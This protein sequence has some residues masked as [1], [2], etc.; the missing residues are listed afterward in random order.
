M[1]RSIS[2]LAFSGLLLSGMV[3]GQDKEKGKPA[4]DA[5]ELPKCAVMAD[6]TIALNVKTNTPDGP[7]YFC[8]PECVDKYAKEP[9]KFADAVK[10]QRAALAK[11]PHV[12]VADPVDG[13]PV[14]KSVILTS[15]TDKVYF[16][17]ED[18]K[19][20]YEA[21]P[22]KYKGGLLN[23]YTYQTTC[24]LM[25]EAIDPTAFVDLADG[26]RVYL[27]CKKCPSKLTADPAKY[28][29][30]LMAMGIMLDMDKINAEA[31]KAGA[32]EKKDEKKPTK[33]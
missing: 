4:A 5:A 8:C 9:A 7:V 31:T 18:N 19:K 20:K 29:K 13:K 17:S 10:T 27:C 30:K 14:T 33:P 12:Q 25:G 16:A 24:P 26:S 2:I 23:G 32:A 22:D 11:R 21:A 15:G 6:D 28:S 1:R 3:F